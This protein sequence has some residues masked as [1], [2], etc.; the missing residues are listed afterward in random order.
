MKVNFVSDWEILTG[1]ENME[2]DLSML[3]FA[4][5]NSS[6][7]LFIRFY[8]WMPKCISLGRNQ[9]D[10]DFNTKVDVVRRPTGGRALLH[11]NEITYCVVGKIKDNQ[12]VIETYKM[13]STVLI[14]GFK[15]LGI[16]LNYAGEKGGNQKYCMNIS[17]GAD[18]CYKGK[19]FIGSA[20]FRK[21]GYF[22]QHGA[23]L[24]DV[25][26]EFLKNTFNEE[27]EKEKIITLKEINPNLDDKTIIK[28]LKKAFLDFEQEMDL[29]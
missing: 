23:I 13:I 28:A 6:N 18:I 25:D 29:K 9:K 20:Q 24:K 2:K 7:D 3:D 11:D 27:I 12:S 14:N 19:K 4:I 15:K 5:K 17:S 10:F 16:E 22:L 21:E 8:G 1:K 26:Y